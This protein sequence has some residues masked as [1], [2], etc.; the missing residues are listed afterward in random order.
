MKKLKLKIE[1]L[2]SSEI[3]T[4]EQMKNVM[5]STIGGTGS[6]GCGSGPCTLLGGDGILYNG[7]CGMFGGFNPPC[8]CVTAYGSYTPTS[9]TSHCSS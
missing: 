2:A 9:G 3:L 5:R 6:G 8:L 7:T 4:R 1:H